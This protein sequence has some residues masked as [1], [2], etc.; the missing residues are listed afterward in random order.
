MAD[1]LSALVISTAD[2]RFCS[3]QVMRL[4][5]VCKDGQLHL[6]E[7]FLNGWGPTAVCFYAPSISNSTLLIA[8][9]LHKYF[10]MYLR[11]IEFI[12]FPL[13]SPCKKPL[14]PSCTVQ[15][16]DTKDT[17]MPIP[18]LAAALRADMQTLMLAY[19]N[20]LQPVMEKVVRMRTSCKHAW[21]ARSCVFVPA[22]VVCSCICLNFS[23]YGG[24]GY[25]VPR[26]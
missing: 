18:L 26:L 21:K 24:A 13:R 6:F 14:K 23:G 3:L 5:V 10:K 7:H 22:C 15:M 1:F 16:S 25:L 4:A 12:S 2:I 9:P 11:E 20:H 8:P 17:P 19:G